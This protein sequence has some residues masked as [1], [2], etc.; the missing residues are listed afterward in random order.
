MPLGEPLKLSF[1]EAAEELRRLFLQSVALHMRSD[2]P[3]GVALSGGIDS[4]AV[5]C[6]IRHL[7]P[8][9]PLHA[10]SYIASEDASISE[11]YLT[12]L[13][14]L[15]GQRFTPRHLRQIF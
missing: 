6:C 7:Y 15:P 11:E 8:D 10:F 1:A 9:F 4:S 5:A 2:V 14:A 13:Q 3:V 12:W